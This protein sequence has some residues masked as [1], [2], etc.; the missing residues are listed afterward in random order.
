MPSCAWPRRPARVFG[1]SWASSNGF[2]TAHPL[3]AGPLPVQ[4]DQIRD[5]LAPFSR[6]LLIGGNVF[7]TLLYTPG[8]AVPSGAEVLHLSPEPLELGRTYA[9]RLGV[10]GDPAATLEAMVPVVR[11]RADDLRAREAVEEA[12]ARRK[13]LA[14]ELEQQA[15]RQADLSPMSPLVA[16]HALLGAVPADALV[17]D[18]AP[19]T[20]AHVRALHRA[21]KSGRYFCNR[22]A[23]LGWG[24]PAALGVS[25]GRGREPV[26]CIVG[27]GSAM[28]SPQALWT[29]AHERLPVVFAVID[30]REYGI[31]KRSEQALD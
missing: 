31:L 3:W 12:A 15:A 9:T 14:R 4:A 25:L 18:E 28:Y 24:M 20:M 7:R 10:L 19:A 17:V 1:A 27:D 13:R 8:P 6:L 22:G 16:A 26:L 30:N 21:G 5:A 2:P 23:G 11:A 29:A